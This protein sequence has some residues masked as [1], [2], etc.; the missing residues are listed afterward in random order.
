M[1]RLMGV[2]LVVVGIVAIIS[3]WGGGSLG[4]LG[5]GSGG[6]VDLSERLNASEAERLRIDVR[7]AD[8]RLVPTD[9]DEVH[10]Q[11]VGYQRGFTIGSKRPELTMRERGGA[12]EVSARQ[13]SGFGLSFNDIDLIVEVPR[14]QWQELA[15]KAGSGDL[16]LSELK[17]DLLRLNTGSGDISFLELEAATGDF[18]TGSG[19]IS[20]EQIQA[21]NLVIK[22]GSGD[23]E[24]GR[25]YGGDAS[26]N[27]GSGDIEINGYELRQLTVNASSGD[28]ELQGG[29][30]QVKGRTGSGNIDMDVAELRHDT[31]LH[32]G[33]GNVK[34]ELDHEPQSL[35]VR[36]DGGSGRGSIEWD[37]FIQ[38]GNSDKRIRGAFGSGEVLLEVRTGSGDFTLD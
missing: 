30:A 3:M 25:V 7:S 2:V 5:F 13:Q 8:V 6:E 29:T 34:V 31:S 4:N 21:E 14:R 16:E 20:G 15:V 36:Y 19:H 38:D 28:I 23:I 11:L 24:M 18:G 1:R 12:I 10:A 35:E 22:T 26:F 32:T 9:S 33:S 17:A 27:T 37:G